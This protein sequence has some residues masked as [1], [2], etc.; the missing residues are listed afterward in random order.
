LRLR[1]Q[2][3]GAIDSGGVTDVDG[4]DELEMLRRRVA[5]LERS[6]AAQRDASEQLRRH[7]EERAAE[8]RSIDESLQKE[9]AQRRRSEERFRNIFEYSNDAIV[10]FDPD[11]DEILDANPRACQLLGYTHQELGNLSLG[12]L[13]PDDLARLQSFALSVVAEG[14][15]WIDE[16][17]CQTRTGDRRDVELSASEIPHGPQHSCVLALMRDITDRK[18]VEA[19]V[20]AS[21]QEKEVLLREIHHRVENNLQVVS[22][23]FDLQT[24]QTQDPAVQDMLRECR[25]RVRTMAAIHEALYRDADLARLDFGSYAERLTNQLIRSFGLGA[26]VRLAME[27]QGIHLDIDRAIPCGLIVNELVTNALKYA[28][29]DPRQGKITISFGVD[30]EQEGWLRLQVSDDGIGLPDGFDIDHVSS[31]GLRLVLSLVSQLRGRLQW[32]TASSGAILGVSFPAPDSTA[33]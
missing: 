19:Q 12:G 6:E 25:N 15:G 18:Q 5:E 20:L 3:V 29:P 26:R 16:I 9:A 27:T 24:P 14:Y 8:L 23:L 32:E 33:R 10:V 31:L 22:S 17:S 21:L 13:F 7:V 30:A 1:A 4:N 28:F 2:V 11:H